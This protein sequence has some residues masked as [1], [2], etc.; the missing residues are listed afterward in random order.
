VAKTPD[1]L[2]REAQQRDPARYNPRN[3][4]PKVD[5]FIEGRKND[6]RLVLPTEE[7]TKFADLPIEDYG[8]VQ[9]NVDRWAAAEDLAAS[10]GKQR[11]H[12]YQ[13]GVYY[14]GYNPIQDEIEVN[15]AREKLRDANSRV[16]TFSER[17]QNP[18]PLKDYPT[19][20][21]A[22]MQAP[23][24]T[25][26]D[27]RRVVNFAA[28]W[29]AAD[30]IMSAPDTYSQNN[31]FLSLPP[32]QQLV[33][34]DIWQSKMSEEQ[35]KVVEDQLTAEQ[36]EQELSG[37]ERVFSDL[38]FGTVS[39]GLDILGA[40][41]TVYEGFQ[42][43]GRAV[44]TG[45]SQRR[46]RGQTVESAI[47]QAAL[48][49]PFFLWDD[50]A[51]GTWNEQTINEARE[52][53]GDDI[54]DVVVEIQNLA[55]E[56]DPSPLS[57]VQAKYYNDPDKA[58][59]LRLLSQRQFDDPELVAEQKDILSAADKIL[60]AQ[61]SDLGKI[62]TT[63]NPV[64][65]RPLAVDTWW[66]GSMPQQALS[67]TTNVVATFA[68]D[69]LIVGGKVRGAYLGAKYGLERLAI[70][71][72]EETVTAALRK[73]SV[74]AYLEDLT[75]DLKKY[76][77][78]GKAGKD[79]SQMGQAIA[80]RYQNYFPEDVLFTMA[81]EGI[82][83]PEAF[84]KYVNDTNAMLAIERGR[85]IASDIDPD[86]KARAIA[87]IED[88]SVFARMA[89]QQMAKRGQPLLPRNSILWA[90]HLRRQFS[91]A[92]IAG[93]K[94]KSARQEIKAFYKDAN[95][96]EVPA[97]AILFN[98]PA[99]VSKFDSKITNGWDRVTRWAAQ[100]TGRDVIYTADAR[101]T[102]V[103]YRFARLFMSGKHAQ[104]LA[105]EWRNA[106]Q[107]R[108]VLMWV[109]IV[110]SAA[111]RRGASEISDQVRHLGTRQINN[112][113]ELTVG[114][115]TDQ[116]TFARDPRNLFSPE[117]M[118]LDDVG[119]TF[120]DWIDSQVDEF[121]EARAAR[122]A[123]AGKSAQELD[124]EVDA[125]R[126]GLLTANPDTIDVASRAVR[127]SPSNF[128]GQQLPLHLWQTSDYL[129]VPNMSDLE[130]ITK[131]AKLTNA[132][133]G[134]TPDSAAN[135]VVNWWS[136]I[137]L[138]GFRY[139]MRN[140]TEDYTLYAL[141]GGYFK[142]IITGRVMSTALREARG[143]EV[144]SRTFGKQ[145]NIGFFAR[146][147]RKARGEA[148]PDYDP[149]SVWDNIVLPQLNKD[150]IAKAKEAMSQGDLSVF[151]QLLTTAVVRQ[152][153]G[154][155]LKDDEVRYLNEYVLSDES[156][157]Q[158]D[159][160]VELSQGLNLGTMPGAKFSGQ[161]FSATAG[162][163][164]IWPRSSFVNLDMQGGEPFKYAY[165]HRGLEGV[166][167]RDGD[168]GKA[169]VAN[170][171]NPDDAVRVV[172]E[173]LQNDTRY[174]YKERLAAFYEMNVTPEEF[175][176]RY[177]QDVRN[178]FSKRDGSFNTGLWSKFVARGADGE[179]KVAWNMKVDGE[180][181]PV[182]TLDE[183]SKFNPNDAP[184]Y[185][186]GKG[187]GSDPIEIP[188]SVS[189]RIW[190][191][192][193]NAFARIGKEPV[194][195]ANYV[196]S[197]KGLTKYESTLADAVGSRAASIAAT[198][199]AQDRALSTTLAFTDNPKNRSMLAYR[200]RNYARYY[201]AQEDFYRRVYRA[202]K[203]N[204]MAFY[205]AYLTI[206]VLDETGFIYEDSYGDKY[207]LYPGDGLINN[208]MARA[209]AFGGGDRDGLYFNN[210]PLT[211][212]GKVTMW[213]PSFDPN[214][215]K[216]YGSSPLTTLGVKTVL[217]LVPQFQKYEDNILGPYAAG[218]PAVES[219]LPGPLNRLMGLMD[220]D[221]RLSMYAG[222][223]MGAARVLGG[224][225]LLPDENA[226][227]EEIGKSWDGIASLAN[228]I[229]LLRFALGFVY[230]AIPQVMDNDVTTYARQYGYDGMTSVYRKLVEQAIEDNEPDPYSAA[231]MQGVSI[232]GTDFVAYR[233][234]K[235][236]QGA[237]LKS[238]P[239]YTYDGKLIEFKEKNGQLISN[240]PS[241]SMF[242][243]P[244]RTEDD[245]YDP[246]SRRFLMENGYR[247]PASISQFKDDLLLAEGRY[248]YEVTMEDADDAIAN[249]RTPQELERA[250]ADKKAAKSFV[251]SMYGDLSSTFQQSAA[252]RQSNADKL[253][254][255]PRDE[256]G[257]VTGKSEIRR[258]VDDF[259]SGK[260]GTTVPQSVEKI[261]EAVATYDAFTNASKEIVGRKRVEV[262]ARRENRIRLLANLR[263]IAEED[264]NAE[265]FI[266]R[267][268]YPLLQAKPDGTPR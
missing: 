35:K 55:D 165:W 6:P 58:R 49:D 240:Y 182:V 113:T 213:A 31:I 144:E 174:G 131:R 23:D 204:P 119:R 28:A 21:S 187:G 107:G 202:A 8:N 98:D 198:R 179:R 254:N 84:V 142:D 115:I 175:A 183:L 147:M 158:L 233:L 46:Q 96:P 251:Y 44:A 257:V 222:A 190:D 171:D 140:A 78:L 221:E 108:R 249:A 45:V 124:A 265:M 2:E 64:T 176:S 228:Q 114:E 168:M 155:T 73:P 267:V 237:D 153:L 90:S 191:A 253:L 157:L 76:S 243:A 29:T 258:M 232:Y 172:T 40:A 101:D 88:K 177:V 34:W 118:A 224:A 50:V 105:D 150:E 65:G 26:A 234:G 127:T 197:R 59:I 63:T 62:L 25:E 194:Y 110:R 162:S 242:L 60:S 123:T 268:M 159:D 229:L 163:K 236:K 109:G 66:R 68:L 38:G 41:E 247:V 39:G 261:A 16:T 170:L 133:I 264:P 121:I 30:A 238:L 266:R 225:G 100:T 230:P 75:S 263:S 128:D 120:D 102:Q 20:T 93:T 185:V 36:R 14:A 180:F 136:L 116:L 61:S 193:G 132:I 52:E 186:L 42:Q 143:L 219:A 122:G 12:Q 244:V 189:E 129:A 87:N 24:L 106:D 72:G 218:R 82:H 92:V 10:L 239:E 74:N 80:R 223:W 260:Y 4:W 22:M 70:D 152:K 141:T 43:Y 32:V 85:V 262:D 215:V 173:I 3:P 205:K 9:A 67:A 220:R 199:I 117:S 250:E 134:A 81:R 33:V 208:V 192:M 231:L 47:L 111:E 188:A 181:V 19:L 7:E 151:R 13:P 130:L 161:G 126:S 91:N 148:G 104:Y 255:G 207:F 37:A 166:M 169:A 99:G 137:N 18:K 259:Y 211:F 206:G 149:Y 217:N 178:L 154:R 103:F 17:L 1:Q 94:G 203:Y 135:N 248:V 196:R 241:A 201:R 209:M 167:L 145:A 227:E 139:S 71:A 95:N 11:E 77:D 184:R 164:L 112:K 146:K 256:N 83:S 200:L 246:A 48:I 156:F 160:L 212:G 195:F 5:R 69:P 210:S 252:E 245:V 15:V 53:Y 214:A 138:A 79:T 97:G 216:P 86:Q 56:G 89:R 235:T 125:F 57:T 51:P 226:T 27:V 54:V